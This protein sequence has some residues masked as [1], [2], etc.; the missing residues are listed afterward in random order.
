MEVSKMKNRLNLGQGGG[1]VS[2]FIELKSLSVCL[3][4]VFC[5]YLT[6]SESGSKFIQ[7]KSKAQ[8]VTQIYMLTP[9]RVI[10]LVRVAE[11]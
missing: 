9:I 4:S 8:R 1:F 5:L 7:H 6:R 10:A 2:A 11:A 3:S